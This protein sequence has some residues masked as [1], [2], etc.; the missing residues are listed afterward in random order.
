MA[1]Y[2]LS[3]I[4]GWEGWILTDIASW[5]SLISV[6][7]HQLSK[8][9][10]LGGPSQLCWKSA[11]WDVSESRR[12]KGR[13]EYANRQTNKHAPPVVV[14]GLEGAV[15][16][17]G[18]QMNLEHDND[19]MAPRCRSLPRPGVW[20][21][22]AKRLWHKALYALHEKIAPTE[23]TPETRRCTSHFCRMKNITWRVISKTGSLLVQ[24]NISRCREIP[25]V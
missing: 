4:I 5:W 17:G 11:A 25:C 16:P 18:K 22:A 21:G 14:G 9:A 8:T 10:A 13:K 3:R 6:N 1:H 15:E 23:S 2:T 12:F 20:T 19:K 7:S 24:V